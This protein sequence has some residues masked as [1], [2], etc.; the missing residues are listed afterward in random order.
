MKIRRLLAA[1]LVLLLLCASAS[2]F[3]DDA[4]VGRAY[5]SAVDKMTELGVLQGYD[6]GCFHPEYTLTRE[7]GAKIIAY[8][9]LGK[10]NADALTCSKATYTDVA[11]DRWS[12]PYIAWCTG[13]GILAGSGG[14]SSGGGSSSGGAASGS[15]NPG[16]GSSDH[17]S[18]GGEPIE[19]A[20]TD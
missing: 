12:A 18:G 11:A 7:Q 2:A 20:E 3:S 15:G 19:D 14:G 9:F 10:K 4:E 13:R 6:D 17:P 16:G 5:R 1:A 8:M